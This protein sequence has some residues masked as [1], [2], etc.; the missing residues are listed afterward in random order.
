MKVTRDGKAETHG[1]V[2]RYADAI[3]DPARRRLICVME[4]HR[5]AFRDDG[6]EDVTKVV[7]SLAAVGLDGVSDPILLVR[8]TVIENPRG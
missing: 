7:N 2:V 8:K 3:A 4:D 5:K 6:T 1:D